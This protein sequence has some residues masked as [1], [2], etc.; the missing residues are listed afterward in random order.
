MSKIDL[1]E[2]KARERWFTVLE[3]TLGILSGEKTEWRRSV[4]SLFGLLASLAFWL[5]RGCSLKLEAG[6]RGEGERG[7]HRVMVSGIH[8]S[9]EQGEGEL[10]LI[11][12]C[13]ARDGP[14]DFV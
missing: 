6:H 4:G 9:L 1:G 12:C 13:S 8:R 5:S 2:G 3:V 10:Q 11:H 7:S 14:E